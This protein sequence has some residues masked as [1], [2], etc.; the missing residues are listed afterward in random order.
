[1]FFNW[2][3]LDFFPILPWFK[4]QIKRNLINDGLEKEQFMLE[5]DTNY[6]LKATKVC[7]H[8]NIVC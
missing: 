7:Y 4:M 8:R 2:T 6:V 1:M 5:I 3:K